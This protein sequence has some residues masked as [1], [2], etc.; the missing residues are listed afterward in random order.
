[1]WLADRFLSG[2]KLA[3]SLR[4]LADDWLHGDVLRHG[5]SHCWVMGAATW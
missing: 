2:L 4:E 5:G 3:C 1:M